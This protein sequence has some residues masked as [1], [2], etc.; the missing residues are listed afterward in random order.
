MDPLYLLGA[1]AFLM[2]LFGFRAQKRFS[3]QLAK[4]IPR[5]IHLLKAVHVLIIATQ[6]YELVLVVEHVSLLTLAAALILLAVLTASQ[7]GTEDYAA[8][9]HRGDKSR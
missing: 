8:D 9:F 1:V 5:K 4:H 3:R 6:L 2:L 7:S